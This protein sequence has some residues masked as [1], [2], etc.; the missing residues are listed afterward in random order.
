[1]S[2]NVLL[3]FGVQ[4]LK[5]CTNCIANVSPT[6]SGR[7]GYVTRYALKRVRMDYNTKIK[8]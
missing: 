6:S 5:T 2:R 7:E 4:R 3:V 1:M 8:L